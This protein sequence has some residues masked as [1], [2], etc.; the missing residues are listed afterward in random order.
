MDGEQKGTKVAGP[1]LSVVFNAVLRAG[2]GTKQGQREK[3]KK[4]N[5]IKSELHYGNG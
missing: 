3:R 2:T 1:L 4:K 5:I